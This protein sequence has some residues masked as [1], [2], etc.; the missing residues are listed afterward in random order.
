MKIES[1]L[2]VTNHAID[3]MKE[4]MGIVGFREIKKNVIAAWKSR[5]EI[6][7]E[8]L[9]S[10]LNFKKEGLETFYYRKHKGFIFCFQKKYVD[11]V[12]ITVFFRK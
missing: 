1:Y 3:R 2:A 7:E 12:L 5:Q 11:V 6:S 4:R 10:Y 9:N 8:F